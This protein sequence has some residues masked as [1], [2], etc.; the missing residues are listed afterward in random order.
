MPLRRTREKR[1]KDRS[2]SNPTGKVGTGVAAAVGA[3]V[4]LSLAVEESPPPALLVA[5]TVNV[6]AVP[7]VSP[8]T[9]QGEL[10]QSCVMPP[11][12]AVTVYLVMVAPPL[13]AGGVNVTVA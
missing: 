6:Y 12:F 11:G 10:A 9:V 8:V 7:L 1:P 4:A 5:V 13:L 3:G 2:N